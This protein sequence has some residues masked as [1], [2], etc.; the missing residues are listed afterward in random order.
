MASSEYRPDRASRYQHYKNIQIS[1]QAA[2]HFGDAYNI[3]INS[4]STQDDPRELMRALVAADP[5]LHGLLDDRERLKK[6]KGRRVAGTCQWIKYNKDYVD[7]LRSTASS[8]LLWLSGDP[9]MG[10]TMLSIY[11]AD[12]LQRKTHRSSD[13]FIEFYCE[14]AERGRNTATGILRGLLF[15]LISKYRHLAGCIQGDFGEQGNGLFAESS[16]F[17]L[18]RYFDTMIRDPKIGTIYC[19]I[20]ALDECSQPSLENLVGQLKDLFT[21]DAN[22]SVKCKLKLIVVSRERPDILPTQLSSFTRISLGPKAAG[23]VSHALQGDIERF[24]KSKVDDLSKDW[25]YPSALRSHVRETFR[26]RACG[27]FLWIGIAAKELKYLRPS[28]VE[29]SLNRLPQG[30]YPLFDRI[31]RQTDAKDQISLILKWVVMAPSPLTPLEL[32]T[33]IELQVPPRSGLSHKE[34]MEHLL[35]KCGLLIVAT[36]KLGR[37]TVGLIHESVRDYLFEK[38]STPDPEAQLPYVNKEDAT[39]TIARRCLN[40]LQF[41]AIPGY[42][43]QFSHM[44]ERFPLLSYIGNHWFLQV[45]ALT[46]PNLEIF[47]LNNPLYQE[48]SQLYARWLDFIQD[49]RNSQRSWGE[50]HYDKHESPLLPLAISLQWPGLVESVLKSIKIGQLR[51][52]LDRWYDWGVL[53]GFCGTLGSPLHYTVWSL[54][55]RI[56]YLLLQKGADP[57]AVCSTGDTSLDLAIGSNCSTTVRLLLEATE[58]VRCKDLSWLHVSF[59]GCLDE[60]TIEILQMLLEAS[61]DTK[62]KWMQVQRIWRRY[63][64]YDYGR[65]QGQLDVAFL[66]ILLDHGAKVEA[67]N[68]CGETAL[69]NSAER[70]GAECVQLLLNRGSDVGARTKVG[71]TAMHEAAKFGSQDVVQILLDNGADPGITDKFGRTP[72]QETVIHGHGNILQLIL[73]RMIKPGATS[74]YSTTPLHHLMSIKDIAAEELVPFSLPRAP[75]NVKRF[76]GRHESRS[77]DKL[78]WVDDWGSQA[79]FIQLVMVVL[80]KRKKQTF[81]I[82]L[83]RGYEID[84]KDVF[85]Q[86]SL[87]LAVRNKNKDDIELLLDHGAN[88]EARLGGRTV[89][90]IAAAPSLPKDPLSALSQRIQSDDHAMKQRIREHLRPSPEVVDL[91]LNRG[92]NANATGEDGLSTLCLAVSD[93]RVEEQCRVTAM[94][95]KSQASFGPGAAHIRLEQRRMN[96]ETWKDLRAQYLS[97]GGSILE[98]PASRCSKSP[99]LAKGSRF[100][101]LYQRASKC[102]SPESV[103]PEVSRRAQSPTKAKA[104][105]PKSATRVV[106]NKGN[107]PPNASQVYMPSDEF[108]E[109]AAENAEMTSSCKKSTHLVS[110]RDEQVLDPLAR[111]GAKWWYA[112]S[113]TYSFQLRT[114]FPIAKIES[115]S[116]DIIT[117]EVR[118]GIFFPE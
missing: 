56:V 21:T 69:H 62:G 110:L 16:F 103:E 30:I 59:D 15:Q 117:G 39:L 90:Q 60:N 114:G 26:Q 8:Q 50:H 2:P 61:A 82:L 5:P 65:G 48:N 99:T 41:E 97:E 100:E 20:D 19:I 7:W 10:K 74:E 91:L 104:G 116:G 55:E 28:D 96:P 38:R 109:T 53:D 33:A 93:L 3:S 107:Y 106:T 35:S 78:F 83:Q 32:R 57:K 68:S 66:K 44:L 112:H 63:Q 92:A 115:D 58:T 76:P 43:G 42:G 51:E 87:H 27:S 17:T 40:Y 1:D 113:A 98:A 95:L 54:Q 86:T 37:E 108:L 67:R 88:L 49:V 25:K 6:N 31:L 89:L 72:F 45:Q 18:W 4:A 79:K 85:G 34:V 12:E 102:W 9:G 22:A 14:C 46:D 23:D 75:S 94:L 77:R 64:S 81:E 118:N 71:R 105:H 52:Q 47:D 101:K 84:A 70:G 36:N 73:D 111:P 29:A 13:T 80:K 24:I 11:L